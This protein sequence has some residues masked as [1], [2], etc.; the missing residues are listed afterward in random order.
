MGETKT[1]ASLI[2]MIVSKLCFI[3]QVDDANRSVTVV[4]ICSH[5]GADDPG[6]GDMKSLR[7][8]AHDKARVPTCIRERVFGDLKLMSCSAIII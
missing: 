3:S 4:K 7:T 1:I 2:D 8:P 5:A 6:S